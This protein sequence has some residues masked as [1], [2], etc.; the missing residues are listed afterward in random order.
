MEESKIKQSLLEKNKEF[1][2]VFDQHKKLDEK[3]IKLNSKIYLTE[4]EK[5]EEK[6]IKKKKILLK[7][8]ML[9]MMTIFKKTVE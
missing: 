9:S 4:D 3:L 5:L 7:D 8:K 1:Q 2:E 6:R